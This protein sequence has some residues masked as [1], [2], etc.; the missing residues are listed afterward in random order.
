MA[1]GRHTGN[2]GVIHIGQKSE[3]SVTASTLFPLKMFSPPSA[4]SLWLK[5][6]R[7]HPQRN[8]LSHPPWQTGQG[9]PTQR[10][11]QKTTETQ[12]EHCFSRQRCIP[13]FIV[14]ETGSH[15]IPLA[16]LELTMETGLASNIQRPVCLCFL[17]TGFKGVHHHAQL[18]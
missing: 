16:V 17:S 2:Q 13:S 6:R 1:G 3:F 4:S 14:V 12:K 5:P 18:G 9:H 10:D 11:P 7:P 8:F 15:Y